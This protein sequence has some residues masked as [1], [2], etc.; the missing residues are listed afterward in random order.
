MWLNSQMY[1][2]RWLRKG[3]H[4]TFSYSQWYI[5]RKRWTIHPVYLWCRWPPKQWMDGWIFK[6]FEKK[7]AWNWCLYMAW[8]S[9]WSRSGRCFNEFFTSRKIEKLSLKPKKDP[10][11]D[12]EIMNPTFRR[13]IE[14]SGAATQ[15]EIGKCL[16]QII[17]VIRHFTASDFSG[18]V[19]LQAK[20]FH[21]ILEKFHRTH[22]LW[23]GPISIE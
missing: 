18:K 11:V 9:A 22:F 17:M 5:C 2:T 21:S 7:W 1:T 6:C 16:Y 14:A 19:S 3:F 13:N 23:R 8:L 10:N 4:R 20:K 15:K 12:S